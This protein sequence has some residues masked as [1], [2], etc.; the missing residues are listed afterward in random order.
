MGQLKAGTRLRSNVCATEVMV[1]M[2][3]DGDAEL[4]CGGAPM[5][6]IGD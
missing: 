6:G 1:V 4:S 3:P 2:A 5:I